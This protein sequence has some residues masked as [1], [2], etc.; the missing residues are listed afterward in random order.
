VEFAIVAPLFFLLIMGVLDFGR[1]FF[2]QM[3][4]QNAL[5]QA[6][7]YA[8]TGNHLADPKNAGQTLSRVAS[9]QQIAQKAAVGLDV[10]NISVSS[11]KAGLGSAGGPG[12]TVTITLNHDLQLITPI[13]GHFFNGGVYHFTVSTSFK[14]EPFSPSSTE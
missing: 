5:R 13:I 4:L 10:G 14:N 2:T 9:I 8:V 3:T 7:R 6:G 11:D 12:D 1:L